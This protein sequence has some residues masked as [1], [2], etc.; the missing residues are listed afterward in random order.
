MLIPYLRSATYVILLAALWVGGR[1]V[2]VL[3]LSLNSPAWL[4]AEAA[5]KGNKSFTDEAEIF[6]C[7]RSGYEVL[8]LASREIASRGLRY[9]CA[10]IPR[11]KLSTQNNRVIW[12]LQYA[13]PD[14]P[15]GA[16][17][18]IRIEVDDLTGKVTF[19]AKTETNRSPDPMPA[20]VTPAAGGPHQP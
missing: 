6:D 3:P 14:P 4:E 7:R 10:P 1:L 12:V 8:E 19:G 15:P 20:S 9:Y 2:R 13:V 5:R 17:Y 16:A 18:G 11:V